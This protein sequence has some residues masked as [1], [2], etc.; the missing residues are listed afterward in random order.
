[1]KHA[2]I[3]VPKGAANAIAIQ[4]ISENLMNKLKQRGNVENSPE[5]M[6][7]SEDFSIPFP[8]IDD[9]IVKYAPYHKQIKVF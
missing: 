9:V 8:I 5:K 2:D 7:I 1:M 4:F 6:H 3:I